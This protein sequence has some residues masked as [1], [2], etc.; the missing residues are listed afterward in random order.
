M[1]STNISR[2]SKHHS[3]SAMK[4]V[5]VPPGDDRLEGQPV[6]GLKHRVRGASLCGLAI[7]ANV[8]RNVGDEVLGARGAVR[9]QP[10]CVVVHGSNLCGTLVH[11][12]GRGL[13]APVGEQIGHSGK[14]S[15][16]EVLGV[17][18]DEF[19]DLASAVPHGRDD[20]DAA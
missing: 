5:V 7:V 12:A 8:D 2:V 18:E 10:D 11:H 6:G 17:G 19:F 4:G 3:P 13:N 9:V 16:I 14:V 20:S 15:R 1:R